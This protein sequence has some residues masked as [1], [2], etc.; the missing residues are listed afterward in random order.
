MAKA[1]S[2]SGIDLRIRSGFRNHAKQ[3]KL[4]KAY[5][6]ATTILMPCRRK[7]RWG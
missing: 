3:Q 7:E 1:A 2:K 6:Q 5:R 4:Y